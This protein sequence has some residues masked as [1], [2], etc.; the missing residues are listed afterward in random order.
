MATKTLHLIFCAALLLSSS[1]AAAQVT[2]VVDDDGQGTA[3]DCAA[4][5]PASTRVG[6]AIAAAGAGDTVLV[7]PGTYV[8]AI[9]FG[10]KAIT[11]RGIG[12]PAVTILD[13]HA[14]KPVV[15]FASGETASS[16]LEGFTIRNG[17]SES[18]GEGGGVAISQS[19][20]V[21]RGNV[22]VGNHACAGSG[23]RVNFGSPVIEDNTIA[24]NTQAGCSGGTG[25]GGIGVGGNSTVVIRRNTITNN[26]TFASG[27]GISLFA[28]GTPTIERNIISGNRA[29]EGGGIWIVNQSDA[30]IAGN[31][32]AG[33]HASSGGG[34]YWLVPSG[35]RGP[36]LVNNT[37]AANDSPSG[38]GVFADGFDVTAVLY[39]NNIVAAAGQTAVFC[40]SSND[41]HVPVFSFNNVFSATGAAYGGICTDQTGLVGNMSADPLFLDAAANDFRLRGASPAIDAAE[42]RAPSLPPV[43]LDGRPRAI[44][45]NR[46]G[47]A[48]V[49][50]GAYEALAPVRHL[51][52]D[53]PASGQVGAGFVVFGWAV[54]GRGTG[55]GVDVVHLWAFPDTGGAP[56]FVG[57]AEYGLPRA[58]VAAA[59][60]EPRYA[61][62]G[63]RLTAPAVLGAGAYTLVAYA[64]TTESGTF[65]LTASVRITIPSLPFMVMDSPAPGLSIGSPFEIS[66]WAID[67]ASLNGSGVDAVH[68]YAFPATGG[69]P[70]FLGAATYG[71]ARP[72]VGAAFGSS[73]FAA[74][75]WLLAAALAPGDYNIAVYARST[76]AQAFN[77]VVTRAVTVVQ[78]RTLITIDT[79][80]AGASLSQPFTISGW[81]IDL[82]SV[83]GP[84]VHAV[85]AYAF[86]SS[87]GP[88]IFL[89]AASYGVARPD[90]AA[91]FGDPRFTSSGYTVTAAGL[92]AGSYLLGV[93][94]RS[95]LTN[96]FNAVQTTTVTV[97]SA[98][99]R[100][101]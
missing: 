69:A 53:L 75:G 10:G 88:P 63:F 78:S 22:I 14:E 100:E 49:D 71:L 12:G 54:D 97:A 81:A 29:L 82:A 80:T 2:R 15:T 94:A 38:S 66:G 86:P 26:V 51:Q 64:R 37:I 84:G 25:G 57:A 44:D 30:T 96:S 24:D 77:Q 72:D 52:L 73:R 45:G 41:L 59:F 33:N 17:Y 90:V 87:G 4:A 50:I 36:R 99:R 19:S 74:S 56:T 31:L 76:V 60:G 3:S 48:T 21:I 5:T 8:E 89:G 35:A 95:T 61:N 85:H 42:D 18:V 28:A 93:Y 46:D 83:S 62:S 1:P 68:A 67:Y 70:V 9:N 40:G 65:E 32:I 23:I 39:N 47:L 92:P 34:V 27:G 43:D 20:P 79:P 6:D 98:Q 91:A 101:R 7:C 13:G 11:V 55:T 58:D 16:V